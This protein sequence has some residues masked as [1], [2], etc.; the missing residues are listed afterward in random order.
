MSSF[1]R[2]LPGN[3]PLVLDSPHSGTDYPADFGS[4]C[5]LPALRR[6]EDT[7]VDML[8]DFAPAMGA[9]WVEAYFPRS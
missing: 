2:Y 7:Y 4:A 8:Y 1:V 5:P 6:T 3:S 9:A